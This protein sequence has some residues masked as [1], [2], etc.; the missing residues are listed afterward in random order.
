MSVEKIQRDL[1]NLFNYPSDPNPTTQADY[2]TAVKNWVGNVI[3]LVDIGLWQPETTYEVGAIVRTPSLP[4]FALRCITAGTS[5][6]TEP[7]YTDVSE[8]DTIQDNDVE[9]IICTINTTN[10]STKANADASNIGVNAEID[11]SELWG[12]AIGGGEIAEDDGKLVTGGTVYAVTSGLASD[13]AD[14]IVQV[15]PTLTISGAAADAK[16]TGGYINTYLQ[17]FLNEY[18]EKDG[19]NGTWSIGRVNNSGGYISINTEGTAFSY[20]VRDVNAGELYHIGVQKSE[21]VNLTYCVYTAD[22][23]GLIKRSLIA[24]GVSEFLETDIAIEV[25][26]TKLYVTSFRNSGQYVQSLSSK[27]ALKNETNTALSCLSQELVLNMTR[28]SKRPITYCL[29]A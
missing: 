12:S 10:A 4:V 2:I 25:G 15:D 24:N 3:N 5:D 6:V 11:N 16:A 17:T 29:D 1:T 13:I 23:S 21:S 26:E 14:N 22:D 8:G 9:W 18:T 27:F 7:D 20:S 28:G 19:Y